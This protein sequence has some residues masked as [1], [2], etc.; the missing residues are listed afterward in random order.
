MIGALLVVA[1]ASQ[2]GWGCVLPPDLKPE[3]PDAGPSSP[4]I[5]MS[6]SPADFA[7]PG[8][9]TIDRE[10]S[11]P[12][13][14]VVEDN[15]LRDSIFV[16]IYRD[17]NREPINQPTPALVDCGIAGP[18]T[19]LERSFN[20]STNSLCIGIEENDQRLRVLEA[21]VADRPFISD[22]DPEAAGQPQYRALQDRDSAAFS[23]RDW[24]MRCGTPQ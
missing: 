24:S 20:C 10:G 15:D 23:F 17:Y 21:M 4:P 22:S 3:G 7:F 1:L 2:P 6:A 14:L 5:I 12:I 11:Q 9:I 13:T 16:R 8:P 19:T 18:S